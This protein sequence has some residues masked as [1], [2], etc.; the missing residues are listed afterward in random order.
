MTQKPYQI[1]GD[2]QMG[3][4]RQHFVLQF[5]ATSE[6]AA[7][8]HAYAALGSRHGVNRRQVRIASAKAIGL[9]EVTDAATRVALDA[10]AA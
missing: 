2:F 5:A 6:Q 7:V 10:K 9:D 1:E 8:D 3:R 4:N